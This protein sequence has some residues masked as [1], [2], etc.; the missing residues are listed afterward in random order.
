MRTRAA[1]LLLAGLCLAGL[2]TEDKKTLEQLQGSWLAVS[3]ERNGKADDDIKG[4]RLAVTG[5]RFVLRLAD[6][7]LYEGTLKVDTSAKPWQI[8]F[9][10]ASGAL[11]GKSWKGIFALEVGS[12]KICDNGADVDKDRPKMFATKPDSGHV[13]VAFKREK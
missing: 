8:D 7:V 13:L 10:H 1:T 6:K 12:L 5:D 4:H 9:R 11:K 3:A 2:Q